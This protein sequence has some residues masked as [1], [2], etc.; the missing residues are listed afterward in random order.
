LLDKKLTNAEIAHYILP[1]PRLSGLHFCRW[2]YASSLGEFD[3]VG[4]KSCRFVW[5]NA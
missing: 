2:Q 3:A 5:N 1:K 4:S